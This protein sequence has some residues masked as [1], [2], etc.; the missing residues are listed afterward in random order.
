MAAVGFGLMPMSDLH[1]P[2]E[3]TLEDLQREHKGA[4]RSRLHIP[5]SEEAEHPSYR[6]YVRD[7][8]L[9]YNDGLVSTYAATAG[10]AGAFTAQGAAGITGTSIGLVGVAIGVAGALS[11][12]LGEYI[13]T[14]SQQEYYDSE[15]AREERHI[16]KYPHLE[17]LEVREAL[18]RKGLQGA[19]LEDA[20]KAITDDPKK[21]LDFMMREEFGLGEE[22]ERNPISAS[23]LIFGAFLV[24]AVIPIAPYFLAAAPTGLAASTVASLGGLF[25]A[26]WWRARLSDLNPWKR[27]FEMMMLG[28]AAAALTFIIG[29][30]VGVAV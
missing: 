14:K 26:G 23:A 24:G 11:M 20:V 4:P 9:G 2:F 16:A 17:A 30:A 21:L 28:A 7:L 27:G 25:A 18:E 8:I 3:P 12:A 1:A 22:S 5:R 13:S 19:T 15:K 6:N 10:V 29:R